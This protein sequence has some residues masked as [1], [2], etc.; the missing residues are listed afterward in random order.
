MLMN[1]LGCH[2]KLVH[3]LCSKPNHPLAAYPLLVQALKNGTNKDTPDEFDAVLNTDAR[4][5][6]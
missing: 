3:T 1:G 2:F 5:E 4:R 6:V